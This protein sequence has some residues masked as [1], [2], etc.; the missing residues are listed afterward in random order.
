MDSWSQ[1]DLFPD[2]CVT[3]VRITVG[4]VGHAHAQAQVDVTDDQDRVVAMASR[5]HCDIGQ[6]PEVVADLVA[7]GLSAV[8]V[9]HSP[10]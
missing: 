9:R 1:L 5:H 7:I 4:C 6:L 8:Y 2:D 3:T 10:F